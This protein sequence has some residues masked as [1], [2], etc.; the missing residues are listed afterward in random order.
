MFIDYE[1]RGASAAV[2]P[3]EV[4]EPRE[5]FAAAAWRARHGDVTLPPEKRELVALLIRVRDG[6]ARAQS[7]LIRRYTARLAGFVRPM[8]RQSE[9]VQDVVQSVSL[10]MVHHLGRLRD[11]LLFEGWLFTLARNAAL[12]QL[13]RARCRPGRLADFSICEELADTTGGGS[14]AEIMEAFAV[15]TRHWRPVDRRIFDQ[16]LDGA[17]YGAVAA[18][19]GLTVGAV[20]LR[21]HRLRQSLRARF[22][23]ILDEPCRRPG[24]PGP[25]RTTGEPIGVCAP[26]R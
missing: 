26:R 12:D 10:K 24:L 2:W 23:A 25:A 7:D 16:V 22:R 15:A 8:L 19:E 6:E 5:D 11:P 4:P 21:V 17:T 13:R 9:T 1:N 3:A 14:C 18:R 20:K